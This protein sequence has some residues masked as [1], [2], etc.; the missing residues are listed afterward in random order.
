M[1]PDGLFSALKQPARTE[2]T[3]VDGVGLAV[4]VPRGPSE[5]RSEQAAGLQPPPASVQRS[6]DSR[7]RPEAQK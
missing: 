5:T 2:E 7:D 4:P 3:H 6:E 1:V